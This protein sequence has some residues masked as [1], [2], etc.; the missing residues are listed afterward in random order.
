[1][2]Q[3]YACGWVT[4]TCLEKTVSGR[5]TAATAGATLRGV[6]MGSLLRVLGPS[7]GDRTGGGTAGRL[8]VW[9]SLY[10]EGGR[11][12]EVLGEV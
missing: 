12:E 6:A 3:N 7:L 8:E 11:E 2:V 5:P 9:W 4:F 10:V 1:M